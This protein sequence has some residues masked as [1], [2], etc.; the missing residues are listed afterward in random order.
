MVLSA[1]AIK[2]PALMPAPDAKPEYHNLT[3]VITSID[4]EQTMYYMA[5]PDTGRKVGALARVTPV[6]P[7]PEVQCRDNEPH[8]NRNFK[9]FNLTHT[10]TN[11]L[12]EL[13]HGV[14]GC[15]N[16]YAGVGALACGH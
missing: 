13:R 9:P 15:C 6:P 11:T 14:A 3:A 10:P 12:R 2:D 16:L 8:P 5:A 4:S 7:W 1:V